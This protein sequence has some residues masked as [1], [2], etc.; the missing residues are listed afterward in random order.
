MSTVLLIEPDIVLA[1][2][3]TAAL[4]LAGHKVSV[5]QSAQAAIHYSD[6]K[7]LELV[8]MELQ[9]PK[10][11]GVEFLY[12]FR[13]YPEWQNIP[14]IVLSNVALQDGVNQLFWQQMGIVR[15]HYKPR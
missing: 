12:E 3:Y 6:N 8:I 14:V 1:R 15:Y 7:L 4:K 5:V 2:S 10:N 11:N 13:S 9:L